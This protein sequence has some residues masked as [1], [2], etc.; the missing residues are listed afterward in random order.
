MYRLTY[1]V[2]LTDSPLDAFKRRVE[3][4][5]KNLNQTL[6]L[7]KSLLASA[8]ATLYDAVLKDDSRPITGNK[9]LLGDMR[10]HGKAV[11]NVL[12]IETG[13]LEDLTYKIFSGPA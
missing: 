3:D 11:I 10:V 13:W 6:Q 4:E 7:V 1:D 8:K 12:H 2:V 5:L 9:T